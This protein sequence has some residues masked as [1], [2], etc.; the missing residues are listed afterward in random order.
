MD[1]RNSIASRD[2]AYH[3]HP[4]T[5]LKKQASEGP[6]VITEGKGIYVYDET[7]KEY[8]EGLAGLWCT[9][10]GFGEERLVEA[11]TRQMRRLPFY[12]L[13]NQKTHEVAAELAERLIGLLPP[14][15]SKVFFNNSGSEANDT[16]VKMVWYYNNA[17]GR[18]RK[19]K[20][21]ARM[22]GYHGVTVA[23]AS[24][25]GLPNNHRDFDLPIG[26]IRHADCPHH[27]RFG[28]P[29]ES[30]EAFA[31]RLADSLE[32]Q[33]LR[34]DP[35][36]V[37][38]FI[39]EPVMGAGGVILPPRGYF[40]KVQR[41][42]KK[43][44]VLLIADEV[45]CGFG[46]TGNMFGSETYGIAPDIMTMAKALSSAYLP[47]SAT[48]V[49]EELYQAFV[50]QSEKIG[51]F[52]HGFTYSGHP[53]CAAVALE[54]LKLYEERDILAHVRAVAPRLQQ[55]LQRF[56]D[57]PL[58]GE[59]RGVGLIAA[60]ELIADKAS[61][62]PFDPKQGVGALFAARAQEH[63]LII[64]AMADAIALC[65]PLV[66]TADEIDEMLRRFA[67]TLD[68]ITSML[69]STAPAA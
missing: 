5:H 18:H 55:G 53:V 2:I 37:A 21:I 54:T 16:A 36:T 45:I 14:T 51:T 34:E 57:H 31:T 20:I 49:S 68:E 33:I 48:A 26:P 3:L 12:H 52:A 8:I 17:L 50:A 1:R 32:A 43:Y 59:V 9:S 24:L 15:M 29:G 39:V 46:R 27:Y 22:K 25:T 23:A 47:I 64:R 6:L 40:E 65:P 4:Y 38:A 61:K 63:G 67:E 58:V 56:A 41:V 28:R 13:F 35:D 69:Q 62:T 42:L 60:V 11:A 10:L 19:K 66:I 7:G 30:E 44:D